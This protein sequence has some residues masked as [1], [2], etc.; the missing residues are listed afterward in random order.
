[1][2]GPGVSRRC[3][4]VLFVIVTLSGAVGGTV[5]GTIACSRRPTVPASAPTI[6]L[7]PPT[8]AASAFVEITGLSSAELDGLGRGR[9]SAA[10]WQAL[11]TV[12]VGERD[13]DAGALPPVQGRYA[14]TESGL[15]F[16]PLFPFDPG[17]A[18]LVRFDPSRLPRPR[19]L[20]VVSHV[21]RLT[22][23]ASR[24]STTV[25]G[26]YPAG[27]VLPENALRLYIEFSAPMGNGGALDF[28]HLLDERGHEVP[29]PFLPVQAD[30]WNADHTRYTLFF[31]PGRVK[32]G[33]LPN[34]QL[35]RPLQAGRQYTIEV[36]ADW[37]DAQAQ[38]LVAPYRRMFRI[39]RA[40]A[41]PLSMASWRIT[42]PGAGSL[43]PLVV[44]FPSALDHGLLARALTVETS[45]GRAIDGMVAVDAD[46]TRWTLRPRAPWEAGDYQLTA[47]SIL[48]DPA[49][50]RIGRAFEVDMTRPAEDAPA[51][52]LRT[53]FRIGGTGF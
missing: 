18:Y 45:A 26:V 13:T 5:G 52:A 34:Q 2:I 15:A 37:H 10:D 8:A 30:F 11:L 1:M 46:D 28:V 48:E 12:T 49:G 17:R 6:V 40:Q 41:R 4:A 32:S 7:H 39:G 44:T 25:T 3:F 38:P 22:A 14:V 47:L 20:P 50:N 27:A 24:P 43:D 42:P 35:G 53:T 23:L 16:T 9:L 21:V 31:D 19:P 33:I 51:E 29:T 36:S